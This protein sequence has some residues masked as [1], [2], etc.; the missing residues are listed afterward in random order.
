MRLHLV[1][2]NPTLV[3]AWRIHFARYPDVRIH[4]G[5]I[6]AVAKGCLVSPAN[7]YG[8]MDGGVDAA[9]AR[10][11]GPRV[12]EAVLNLI[13]SRPEGHLPVGAAGYVATRHPVIPYLIVAPTMQMP[14]H[15]PAVN[16]QRA[17]RAILRL[18]STTPELDTD[19]Y[20]PGLG[21]GVGQIDPDECARQM[22]AGY[23]AV[24]PE[25]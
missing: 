15:M 18:V 2:D 8:Y 6:L 4:H 13:A 3:S 22:A 9:Y 19:V 21:S 20:C 14:E 5:D 24:S 7:S 11:F 1:D 23:S 25:I 16:A 17:L 10:F 12:E